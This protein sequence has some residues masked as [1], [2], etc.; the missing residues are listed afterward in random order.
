[1]SLRFIYGRAGSG[2][3]HFC[4]EDIKN[5]VKEGNR[6]PLILLVP[7]QFSFQSEKNLIKALG[8]KNIL[9]AEVLS[10][11][12]MAYKVFSEVGGLTKQHMDTSGR[13]MLIYRIID[14][15]KGNLKVFSKAVKTQGFVQILSDTITEMKRY[16]ITPE[17][18]KGAVDGI[19]DELLKDK[20]SDIGL[21]YE[22][23]EKALH[24]K[25]IDSEDDLTMLGEK[26]EYSELF[27]GGEIWIDEFSSFTPQQYTIIEKLMRMAARVNVTLCTDFL[28]S[29]DVDETDVFSQVKLTQ[30]KLQKLA[31]ENNIKIETPV[32]LNKSTGWRYSKSPEIGHLERHMF[33]FPYKQYRDKTENIS[34]FK[35][36]N[37]YSEVEEAA[38]DIVRVCRDLGVR[39]RDIAVVTRDL[40]GYENLIG[41]IFSEYEIPHF[42]DQ[43]REIVDNPL[44]LLI[45]SAVEILTRNWAYEPVF[46]Y[47]KTGLLNIHKNDVDMLE[48]YVLA[49]G[50]RGRRW[51]EESWR[52]RL[53]YGFNEEL[54]EYESNIITRVNGVKNEITAPLVSFYSKIKKSSN[55]RDMAGSLYEFLCDIG[56][57]DKIEG[58]IQEFKETGELDSASEYSQI[59]N[60]IMG[61]LDQIVEVMGEDKLSLD[62]FLKILVQGLGEY[63]IGLIPPA[64]DQVLVGSIDRLKSH[65]ISYLYIIGVND[66][67]FP[68]AA[69][70]EGILND[71]DRE[72]LRG[73]GVELAAG[74]GTKTFEEQFLVYSAL[75]AAGRYL[76]LSYPIADHE[77]KSMRP[78]ILISRLKKLF[79]NVNEFS[80]I[81]EEDKGDVNQVTR[82]AATFNELVAAVR[83]EQEGIPINPIWKDVKSWYTSREEWKPKLKRISTAL[84]YSNEVR[85]KDVK[86]VRSLYGK[87]M[88]FSVSRL[89]KYV[90]CPFAY[91][92]QYGLKAKERKVYEMSAPDLGSFLHSVIDTFSR[93][94]EENKM[95]WHDVEREWCES[96]VTQIVD[97]ITERDVSSILTSSSRYKYITTR[98]KR[99]LARAVWLIA[100]HIKRSGFEPAGYEVGFG[101][102]GDFPPITIRLSS[103]EKINLIGRIDRVDKLER[104]D[105]T[106]I[107]VVDYKSGNKAFNLSDVYNG[108][109]IQLL[110]YLDAMLSS[111]KEAS[112]KP[113]LP[114]GVL[115]FRVDDPIIKTKGD[116]SDEE[117]EKE[118]MKKLKMK[119]L[120]LADRD[121]IKEMDRE[122]DGSSNIIP[123]RINKDGTLGKSSAA[124][125][126]QFDYLRG[127]VRGKLVELCQ[128]MADGNIAIS[129]Y[130]KKSHTPCEYC[131]LSSVCKFDNGV[132]GNK[133]KIISD[134]DDE[135]IWQLITPKTKEEVGAENE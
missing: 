69:K 25:Y 123:A 72:N 75:T 111:E 85:L 44:V 83:D 121:V 29:G 64:L 81:I 9:R 74:T 100:L 96:K 63:N 68:Q 28:S 104:E 20:L 103:G 59:W 119:G 56:I 130:K 58:L 66:G 45:T 102:N 22:E 97:E 39:Y 128:E 50:I 99:V 62:Q 76:R 106:Y 89:E 30:L 1:M 55:A 61:V 135:E 54:S 40:A 57:P 77:G 5:N 84:S 101:I 109:Q 3:S 34:I 134:L 125:K 115:Y 16:N 73:I 70:D 126:E 112:D 18:V 4:L 80:N 131:K 6:E 36:V 27:K 90:E 38:K 117:I 60:M 110:V 86:K 41:A 47:L 107:R 35:S 78:S 31:G 14:R 88:Y 108:L 114:G 116:I 118:I 21:I 133:Y 37:K 91:F 53:N 52:Y 87:E 122:I 120:L 32:G 2:K 92:V 51:L 98:L 71:N 26:L 17:I 46:R 12:R 105:G 129:P 19:Q 124:T 93:T 132:M 42:I 10:F 82:S 67:I 15:S 13:A 79:P 33:S 127:H 11:K 24:E 49:N 43:K 48:N 113:I 65:D 8:E 23:F 94:L 7:E 95:T